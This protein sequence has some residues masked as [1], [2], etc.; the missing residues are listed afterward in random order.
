[1]TR[2][3]FFLL[4][5]A[6]LSTQLQTVLRMMLAPEPSERP[7]VSELLAL[8]SVWKHRW[9]RRIYLMVAETV[10]TLASVCQVLCSINLLHLHV[11]ILVQTVNIKV[12]FCLNHRGHI[13]IYFC[14]LPP[15]SW[16]CALVVGCCPPFTCPFSLIGPSQ[17]PALLLRI[18]GIGISPSLS[19]PC[20]L[21]QGAQRMTQCFSWILHIQSFPRLSHTGKI[22]CY[23]SE[24][25]TSKELLTISD[26]IE[27][28]LSRQFLIWPVIFLVSVF[29][30][31]PQNQI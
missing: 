21:T 24:M 6:G 20:M 4:C 7:T 30:C 23:I 15:R 18:A 14:F 9:K 12:Y 13:F 25:F 19:V 26:V 1:M 16:W 10:L 22:S 29:A 28:Y 2:D 27:C 11:W 5:F 3:F 8:P 17:Y 31:L